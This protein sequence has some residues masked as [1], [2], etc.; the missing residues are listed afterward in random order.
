MTLEGLDGERLAAVAGIWRRDRKRLSA[1]FGGSSMR[2]A[3]PAGALL[4]VA[5][6]DPVAAGDVAVLVVDGRVV[7]HR[8][9]AVFE[10]RGC[11]VTRGDATALPDLP[12]PLSSVV[13]RIEAI[14]S[15]R[16]AA[17][18]PPAPE[19]ASRSAVLSVSLWLLGR[20]PAADRT[21][22][23]GL[24]ILRRWLVAY[25]AAAWRKLRGAGAAPVEEK[26]Q[27]EAAEPAGQ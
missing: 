6:G 2:P 13:G 10:A 8:V 23:G 21:F 24:W 17:P 14:Q 18:V 22:V 16:G 15:A 4:L 25:P 27:A 19:S 9:A 11:L 3:I 12:S 5:C 1:R 26:D 7:V 20:W